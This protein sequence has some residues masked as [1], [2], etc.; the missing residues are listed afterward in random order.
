METGEHVMSGY[1]VTIKR[2][3]LN[4]QNDVANGPLGTNDLT[5]LQQILRNQPEIGSYLMES[6]DAYSNSNNM[7]AHEVSKCTSQFFL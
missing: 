6:L 1:I 2:Q 7:P 3:E 4:R 5:K